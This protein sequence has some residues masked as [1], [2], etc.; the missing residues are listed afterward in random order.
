MSTAI[1]R[2]NAILSVLRISHTRKYLSKWAFLL[3]NQF[4]RLI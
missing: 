2:E 4:S 1:L 3:E